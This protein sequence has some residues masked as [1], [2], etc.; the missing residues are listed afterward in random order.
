M[1]S[2]ERRR[3]AALER[4]YRACHRYQAA[5]KEFAR[6]AQPG[7]YMSHREYLALQRCD[8]VEAE[9]WKVIGELEAMEYEAIVG[10]TSVRTSR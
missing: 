2:I 8:E 7:G 5:T 10:D 6:L 3:L 9:M 4:L 1:S